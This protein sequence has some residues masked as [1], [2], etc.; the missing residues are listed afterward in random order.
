MKQAALIFDTWDECLKEF[1]S[2]CRDV[3]RK[4]SEKFIPVKVIAKHASLQERITYIHNFRQSHHQLVSTIE[5]VVSNDYSKSSLD[6]LGL[7]NAAAIVQV[8]SAMDAIKSVNVLDVS[9]KGTKLWSLAEE[10]YVEK[11]SVI[12]NSIS[13]HLQSRLEVCGSARDMFRVFAKFNVL[14][15]RPKIRGA[16]H[17]YQTQ[18]VDRVK[19]DI[20]RLHER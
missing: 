12:E 19:D 2:V 3:S 10:S 15:V 13:A 1:V 18:L 6:D 11:I 9:P 16:I 17:E 8:N 20:K 4:R 7:A 14:F 5:K